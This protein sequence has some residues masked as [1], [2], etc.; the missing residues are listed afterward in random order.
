MSE[1]NSRLIAS[2]LPGVGFIGLALFGIRKGRHGVL[3]VAVAGALCCGTVACGGGISANTPEIPIMEAKHIGNCSSCHF[4]PNFTD[5]GMHNTGA[6]QEEYDAVHGDGAFVSLSIP[7]YKERQLHS[8]DY[9]PPTPANPNAS[10]RFRSP[11]SASDPNLADLGLWNVYANANY[12]EPQARLR[13]LMCAQNSPCD[14]EQ[15]LPLTIGRFKTP[16]L[17]DLGHSQPYLHTG[18]MATIQKAVDFYRHVAILA[19]AGRLRN[20][21]PAIAGIS[22][23]DKDEAAIL[24]FLQSLNEEYD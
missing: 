7:D 15:V 1:R 13:A 23:D 9:L 16:T 8:D 12:P 3:V 24:A 4:A 14:P 11:V 17:R 20:A 19:Q 18:R 5:F 22:I 10:G 2:L 6:S 21:D